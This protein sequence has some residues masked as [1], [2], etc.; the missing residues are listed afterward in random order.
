MNG[1]EDCPYDQGDRLLVS[2]MANLREFTI[3]VDREKREGLAILTTSRRLPL[4]G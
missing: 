3:Y 4:I 1:I 2:R